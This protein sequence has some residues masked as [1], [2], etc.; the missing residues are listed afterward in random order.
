MERI[1]VDGCEYEVCLEHDGDVIVVYDFAGNRIAD[2][3]RDS[4]TEEVLY[5]Y[6]GDC[7]V[8]EEFGGSA[9]DLYR[10]DSLDIAHWLASTHP[11]H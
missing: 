6:Y 10:L 4:A 11:R 5:D 2:A 9:Y 7:G 1:T 3:E 8:M